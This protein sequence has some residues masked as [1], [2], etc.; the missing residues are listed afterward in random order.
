MLIYKYI[1]IWQQSLDELPQQQMS[2]E[3]TN[4]LPT[5]MVEQAAKQVTLQFNGPG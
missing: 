5:S 2:T 3:W 4:P 1:D